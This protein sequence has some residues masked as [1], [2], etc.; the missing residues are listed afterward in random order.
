MVGGPRTARK[1]SKSDGNAFDPYEVKAKWG[2]DAFRYFLIANGDIRVDADY[3]EELMAVRYMSELVGKYA[4]IASRVCG[5]ALE[6]CVPHPAELEPIDQEVVK[7][8]EAVPKAVDECLIGNFDYPMVVEKILV[9][10]EEVNRYLVKCAPWKL[11]KTAQAPE[12]GEDVKARLNTILY[13]TA[14]ALRILSLALHPIMPEVTE[15]Y[16]HFVGGKIGVGKEQF[17]WGGLVSGAPFDESLLTESRKGG[18]TLILFPAVEGAA[19]M[20][21]RGQGGAKGGKGGKGG[22]GAEAGPAKGKGPKGGKKKPAPDMA[23]LELRVGQIRK[24]EKHPNADSLY[25]EDMYLGEELGSRTIV[26]GLVKYH[27]LEEMQDRKVVVVVNL[28]PADMRGVVSSGMVLCAK[29]PPVKE[30]ETA[31]EGP[32]V[33]LLT[34]PAE[35]NPGDIVNIAGIETAYDEV[36]S[37][38]V[39]KRVAKKLATNGE[40]VGCYDGKP[41]MLTKQEGQEETATFVSDIVNGP[42]S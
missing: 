10:V 38:N 11:R 20:S 1:I 33:Q 15:K 30:G 35:G 27:S 25:V 39:W 17:K 42:V 16:I 37:G 18:K 31:P 14:E 4:N 41:L 7:V 26:S 9:G 3:R 40:G 34:V 12:G 2:L 21:G 32:E 6:P 23:R 5:V 24:V 28:K 22:K 13:V 29:T 19:A 8:I 36:V